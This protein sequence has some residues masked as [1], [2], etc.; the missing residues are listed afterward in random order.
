MNNKVIVYSKPD[1]GAC[2]ITKAWLEDNGIEYETID[3]TQDTQAMEEIQ[4]RGFMGFPVVNVDN[5]ERSWSGF[6]FQNL[7]EL[8]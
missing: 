3:A 1:C 4:E 7:G 5:W 8:L 6:D 2:D